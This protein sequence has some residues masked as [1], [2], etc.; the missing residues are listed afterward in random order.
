M[1]IGEY[2]QMMAY[3]TRPGFNGG[4]SGKKPTTIKDLKDSG[5]IVTGD[6]YKPS[7]PKLIQAIR[8]FELRNPRKKN[9]EGGPQIVEPPKSMQV[10]T[11]TSN[12]I[13]EYNIDD[14]KERADLLI[15]GALGGFPKDEMINKLQIELDKVQE[16]GILSKE[17]AI[18]FINQRTQQLREYIKENPGETLPELET[19]EEF[20]YGTVPGKG[21]SKISYDPETQ[22]YRKKVQ[23]TV[24]GKKTYKYIYSEPGQSLEDFKKIKPV[25][26]TGAIEATVKSRQFIDNWT[27][28]WF[29]NNLKNYGVQDF[30]AMI[31]D[32]AND[33][34]TR[35]ESGDAPK[36]SAQFKLSTP[37]L[38]LPNITSGRDV[39]I[40]KGGIKPFNY[41][42]VTFYANLEGS[43]KELG[44]T[45][46]QYKKVFYKNKIETDPQLRSGLN[47]FF[48]FMSR[49]KRGLYKTLDGKTIKDFINTVSDDVKYLLNNKSSGLDK[50][51]KNEVFNAYD[52]L[53]DNYNK[54]TQDKVRLKAVQAET[55]AIAKAG[56]KTA[57]QYK[58]VKETIKKQNDVLA[59]MPVEDI[60]KNKKLLNS[61]RMSINPQTGEV[62]YTNYTVNNPKGKT[63][64]KS[65]KLTDLELAKYI[66][67]KAKDKNFYVTEH[68]GKKSLNKANL[69]YPNNIQSA[70]YM[71]NAQLENAR[72]FLEIPENRNTPAAQ[73]LDKALE[74][75][76]L[77]IRGPE[78]GGKPYG[79]KI[80][81]VFNSDTGRSSIV[82]NQIFKNVGK[83]KTSGMSLGAAGDIPMA[84]E[85]LTKDLEKLKTVF[86][87]KA[88]KQIASSAITVPGLSSLFELP[89]IPEY[90]ELGY[91][92]KEIATQLLTGGMG[93]P[94]KD[95]QER[96]KFVEEKGLGEELQSALRRQMIPQNIRPAMNL[97]ADFGAPQELTAS[98]KQAMEIFGGEAQDVIDARRKI[99]ADEYKRLQEMTDFDDPMFRVGAMGGGI[100][101]LGFAEGPEDPG[102]RKFMKIMGGLATL[103]V[104]G[105]FF[106]AAEP[107]AKVAPQVVEG[108][109]KIP[110]YF[111]KLIDKIKKFGKDETE[112]FA[113]Q[114]KEKVTTYRTSDADYELYEDLETGSTQI[115]I[116][117]G[118]P[119]GGSGYKEQELTLTK[120]QS[121]ES[122][123]V[124]PDQYDEYT[125]RPDTDGKMKDIDEGL[126]D[127][128]DLIEELGPE[129]ISVKELEDMGYDVN[130]LGPTIKKKLGIK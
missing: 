101:R 102:K 36:A 129:N 60:A 119:D 92:P 111:F 122:A 72:R 11:T 30:E 95:I 110:P 54:F 116:R 17:E 127:I 48:E 5:K 104:V 67:Q 73:N 109:K 113:S 96:G 45:L 2:E 82:D 62:S 125:V 44:K 124:V 46:S 118:D 16:S 13:P 70:N 57:D 61:V 107:V 81:I 71:S 106:K 115:K 66:K 78:Y 14:F 33:W 91:S 123:G 58:K 26:S 97:P 128:D 1:K 126:E 42:D 103:P 18:N 31:S 4:G 89:F 86:G 80:D 74:Q 90:Q 6:K 28:N 83:S 114:P 51:A 22:I 37:K 75:T 43:E 29:D 93:V 85:I 99:Q 69:A 25:R 19:R 24:D 41:N 50:A 49:D 38:K 39:T 47:N 94:F 59:K 27:K 88:A 112:I 117:K 7:N 34:N 130:R 8:D 15:K 84:K 56:K 68:I 87:S 52:D 120:G 77:T 55:E 105:K 32:L 20:K 21:N 63:M 53:A 3:L 40:K 35:L 121:N 79:N 65:V 100:M 108:V 64:S 12:P 10:D 76:G 23:E 9:D 98:E